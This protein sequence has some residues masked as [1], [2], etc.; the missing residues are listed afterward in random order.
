[1]V[2]VLNTCT[3]NIPELEGQLRAEMERAHHF[4]NNINKETPTFKLPQLS[5]RFQKFKE[6]IL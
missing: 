4:Q 2:G 5:L 1:M 6:I 3:E